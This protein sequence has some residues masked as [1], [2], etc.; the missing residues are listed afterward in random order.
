LRARRC[1]QRGQCGSFRPA[2]RGIIAGLLS[3]VR[4][5]PQ[6]SIGSRLKIAGAQQAPRVK[7]GN[8]GNL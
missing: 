4:I 8:G 3:A 7:P 1:Q 5:N 6:A 2:L